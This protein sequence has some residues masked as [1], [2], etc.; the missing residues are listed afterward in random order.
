M[1]PADRRLAAILFTDIVGYTA[2]MAESEE[3]G[4]RA[5]QR[6]REL[7]KPIVESYQGESIE[8][9]GDESLSLFPSALDAVNCALAIE[10]A[11]SE[12]DLPLHLGIHIG[13]IVTQD[14]EISGDGVNIASRV[15]ALSEQGGLC[16]SSEVYQAVRNQSNLQATALG[17]HE[18]KNV[19]RPVSIYRM[20]GTPQAPRPLAAPERSSWTPRLSAAAA[21]LLLLALAVWIANRTGVETGP[22]RTLAVLP[23]DNLSGDPTQEFFADGMTEALIGDLAKIG[24]LRVISRTTVMQYKDTNKSLPEIAEELGVDAVVEG[25]IVRSGDRVRL[26]AQLIHARTDHHLWSE[27][28]ERELRDIL[29]LQRE[30]AGAIARQIELTLA[31][32]GAAATPAVIPAAHEAYLKGRYFQHRH[33]PGASEKAIGY[34]KQSV[35]IDSEFALGYAGMADTFSCSPMHTWTNPQTGHWPRLP[36]EVMEE[37]SRAAQRALA[38]NPELSESHAAMGLVLMFNEWN[39]AGAEREFQRSLEL[40]PSNAF[41]R[42]VY[43]VA[44]GY[45]GR[46]DEAIEEAELS[47]GLDPLDPTAYHTGGLW[48]SL[49]GDATRAVERWELALEID[50][51]FR[52]ALG[53]LGRHLCANGDTAGGIEI[54]ER[55]RLATADDAIVLSQL[56]SC[57]ALADRPDDA[58]QILLDLELQAQERHIS[59]MMFANIYMSLGDREQALERLE[60]GLRLR[61]WH[62]PQIAIYPR[63]APLHGDPRY[64]AILQAMGLSPAA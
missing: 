44:L 24:S 48:Y 43:S 33:T 31:P 13:D 39:W 38:L 50:P 22:I 63:W 18:L 58:Q 27:H 3:R 17:D 32:V 2:L 10:A 61:A 9:R 1:A 60:E 14:G 5:K 19:G 52:P 55:A 59:P 15:C 23:L 30:L 56:G 28:Y 20:S 51:E 34:F 37:A 53:S 4:L 36:S 47:S 6:H 40:N 11:A 64:D 49:N 26:T 62:L 54:L 45:L 8:A 21:L 7:V 12:G 41:A 46:L 25:S 42:L 35:D 29:A 16:V 57:Y